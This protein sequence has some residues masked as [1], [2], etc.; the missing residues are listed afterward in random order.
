M[1]QRDHKGKKGDLKLGWTS[2]TLKVSNSP[3]P[4]LVVIKLFR[5]QGQYGIITENFHLQG[6]LANTI[7][8]SL[9]VCVSFLLFPTSSPHLILCLVIAIVFLPQ[10]WWKFFNYFCLT[11]SH[12]SVF[13]ETQ[14]RPLLIPLQTQQP[15][16]LLIHS[17][18]IQ[19]SLI[20]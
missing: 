13:E 18:H 10:C 11:S 19:S 20:L 3:P 2:G 6:F 16:A 14:Q 7:I 5:H 1:K 15:M 17:G 4:K 12:P 8:C 9:V